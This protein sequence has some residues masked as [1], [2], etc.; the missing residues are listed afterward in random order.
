M[1]SLDLKT[2][3]KLVY[4]RETSSVQATFLLIVL[5]IARNFSFYC[6]F[7]YRIFTKQKNINDD[8]FYSR[9]KQEKLI[10]NF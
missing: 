7:L 1:Y 9:K 2:V 4:R 10:F 6:V 3:D 5:R 8:V